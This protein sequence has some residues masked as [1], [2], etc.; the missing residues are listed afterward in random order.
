MEV[1]S[2]S[3]RSYVLYDELEVAEKPNVE[4]FQVNDEE[5]VEVKKPMSSKKS[6]SLENINKIS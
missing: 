2:D 4:E 5:S 3:D 6:K 1:D